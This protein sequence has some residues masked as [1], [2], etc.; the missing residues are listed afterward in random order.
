MTTLVAFVFNYSLNGLLADPDTDF[1]TFCF[2]LLDAH[3][4]PDRDAA[5]LEFL[6]TASA[7][8]MGRSAY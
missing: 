6:G 8:L 3:G 1:W 5:T 4:G 7:H 2:S